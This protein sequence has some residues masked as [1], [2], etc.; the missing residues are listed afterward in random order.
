M[1]QGILTIVTFISAVV[2]PWPLTVFLALISSFVEPL[3]PLAVG[4]FL[5]T[6]YYVPQVSAA[7]M[8]TF[9]GSI[10]TV[11]AFLVRSRLSAGI[12]GE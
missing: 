1:T 3:V 5:D 4:I 2:F 9:Y 6:L 7:P 10:C 12:I 11:F 8:F